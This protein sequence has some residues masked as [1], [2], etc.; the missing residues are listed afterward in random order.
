MPEFEIKRDRTP[1]I[2][3]Q[4]YLL[5][6]ANGKLSDNMHQIQA[7]QMAK[8]LQKMGITVHD[9]NSYAN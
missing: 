3:K 9:P 6:R 8:S 5:N 4:F 2:R 7:A 1:N